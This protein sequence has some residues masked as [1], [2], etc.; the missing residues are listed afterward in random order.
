MA[1]KRIH[2][3]TNEWEICAY[4]NRYQKA[5]AY[6]YLF[7]D[8]FDIVEK[9]TNKKFEF[10]H[11]HSSGG[12]NFDQWQWH[13]ARTYEK[14]NI[15][16]TYKDKSKLAQ[17]TNNSKRSLKNLPQD[18]YHKKKC[19]NKALDKNTEDLF[20]IPTSTSAIIPTMQEQDNYIE[21][22][23]KKLELRHK[24]LEILKEEIAL[25]EKLNSL[26]QLSN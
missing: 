11:I 26:K 8:L 1:F 3:I 4:A 17:L 15:H 2:G 20:S 19:K 25:H 18:L 5:E 9:D 7:E 24:S 16:E 10:Q 23:N 12:N 14:Y 21:W 6:Q 22:E 13:S